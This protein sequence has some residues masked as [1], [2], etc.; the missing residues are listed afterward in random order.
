M[1][2]PLARIHEQADAAVTE[3]H[4]RAVI[5]PTSSAIYGLGQ[6]VRM[7]SIIVS[8]LSSGLT[9]DERDAVSEAVSAVEHVVDL[10]E[11]IAKRE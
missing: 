1:D 2:D 6:S 3:V 7:M 9:P 11:E 4:R 10:I 8:E 5:S